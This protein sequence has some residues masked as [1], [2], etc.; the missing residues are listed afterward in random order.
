MDTTPGRIGHVALNV[1]DLAA[2]RRC[3]EATFGWS[4]EPWFGMDDF[5]RIAGPDGDQPGPFAVMQQRREI[6]GR[7]VVGLEGTVAVADVHAA[8][9]AA[10]AAGGAV[11]V[12]PVAIPTVGTLVWLE[13]PSGNVI[14][15]MQYEGPAGG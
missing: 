12:P 2:A 6:A 5:F 9:E 1:D 15:A 4:F 7:R 10:E 8:I 3:Y 11:L 14:G 13:D